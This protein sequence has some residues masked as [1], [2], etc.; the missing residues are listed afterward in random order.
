VLLWIGLAI[1]LI[2]LFLIAQMIWLSVV[3]SWED[4]QTRGLGY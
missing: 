3:L 4:Q 1:G 2:I